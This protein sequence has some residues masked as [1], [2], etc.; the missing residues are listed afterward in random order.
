[1]SDTTQT[2]S[3]MGRIALRRLFLAGT[4]LTVLSGSTL[5]ADLPL[6]KAPPPVIASS[7]AGFYLGVHGGYGWKHDDFSRSEAEFFFTT[8]PPSLDGVRSQGGVFG[9][10][11]GYNW[12]FGRVVT[13]LE[14]DF[15]ATDIKGSNG[16]SEVF[17]APG[18]TVSSSDTLGE[19]VR[20][21]GSARTR[22]GWLPTDKVLLY[23]TAGL[24]WE[25]LDQTKV[26]SQAVTA[27]G[28]LVTSNSFFFRDPID[29]FGWV[30]GVGAEAMLGSPNWIGRVEY[31]HYDFGQV[32]TAR[33][34]TNTAPGFGSFN[35]SA[36]SQ[37][38]D[39]ARAGIS[40]KFGEPARM[41]AVPYAPVAASAS[42]WAGF[43]LGAHAGYGWGNDPGTE[44]LILFPG[45]GSTATLGGVN[46]K[47]WVGGGQLGYNWQYGRFVTGLEIDLSAAD[48]SGSSNTATATMAVPAAT[49]SG[50][51]DENVKYLG[52]A[53]GRLGWLATDNLLF[54]G[55]AGLAW[56]RLERT[57]IQ[58]ETTPAG[59]TNATSTSPSDRFGWVAGVGG[60]MMLG[61]TNWIGRLEYLHYDFGRINTGGNISIFQ[62]GLSANATIT[63][64]RQTIDVVRAGVS[65]KFGPEMA[66]AVQPAMYTKA[67]RVPPPLQNWAGFYLGAHGGYGWKGNDF[68]ITAFS[69]ALAGGIKS[70]GWLGGG[71][72][73]YNWQYGRAIAGLEIDGSA[74]GIRGSS[75]PVTF[76]GTTG[77]LSDN[78]K[79]LGTARGRLG[80]TPAGDWLLYGTGGLAWERVNRTWFRVS[81]SPN[82]INTILSES[83]RDHFGWV[84]GAGVE[85][86]IHNSNWIARLEY[87]HY[88]FGT[89]ESTT[90]QASTDP[91]NPPFA[92]R[93]GR[94][95]LE[96]V[97]ASLSYKFTP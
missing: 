91:A 20:Y 5:A 60:E 2:G 56:E 8:P 55:T 48:I 29:K 73:G 52:T 70:A 54:Y 75:L 65:Y 36:G 72:A 85:T 19:N 79:Y 4:S 11:A 81:P 53:R 37:T 23:G 78:V 84:A 77:T 16:V 31:L 51:F 95:T 42:S 88:D 38:I 17:V 22:L 58:N 94:Q 34:V 21:L 47:G 97:R 64:G 59:I 43:Y 87:L 14:F 93:G 45:I 9:A 68:A 66:A 3:G 90:V 33:S 89:V 26:Q 35:S 83:P 32:M 96:A 13:G 46:S 80:W 50:R 62:S 76:G 44:P 40:Y 7:W 39:L 57:K 86:M 49:L 24:A 63:A 69:P 71:Q 1:M 61:S 92:E 28:V 74:T 18:T 82:N 6:V 10:H 25:R 67:P 27:N 12:Q 15:S 30:A 41:A